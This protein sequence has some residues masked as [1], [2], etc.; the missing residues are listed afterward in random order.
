MRAAAEPLSVQALALR[1]VAGFAVLAVGQYV[2]WDL[3]V[4]CGVVP[5]AP[6]PSERIEGSMLAWLLTAAAV[7]ALALWLK[8][9][10]PWRPL[11]LLR[12]IAAYVPFVLAW[13]L[14]LVGY[15]RLVAVEPQPAL[16][17]LA[18][19]SLARPGFWIVVAGIVIAAPIAEEIVFRGWLQAALLRVLPRWP[20]ILAAAAVFGLA[21]QVLYAFPVSLLGIFFGWLVV[22]HQSLL[23]S[24]AAHA[25]HNGVVVLVTCL[26]PESL[27][28][29]Y[30]R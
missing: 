11:A 28:L 27:E 1:F 2:A 10:W 30:R 20:A 14:L 21:H 13:A 12:V 8:T 25:L 7:L 17:Y 23:P 6:S 29:L 16:D 24:I 22:R 3:L 19:A 5:V 4:R 15:L 18:N 9:E 26:W